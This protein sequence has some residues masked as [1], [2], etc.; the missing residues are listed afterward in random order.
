MYWI[1]SKDGDPLGFALYRRHYSAKK[2]PHPKIRQF[3]GPGETVVLMGFLCNAL[4]GWRKFIEDS[5]QKGVNCAVFRNETEH[6]SSDM[7]VEA[8]GFAWRRWP[9]ERLYTTIDTKEVRSSNPGCCFLKAGWRKCG[10]TKKRGLLIL[11]A[12][13]A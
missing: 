6:R 13:P 1:E 12:L 7:I 8:M 3:L 11:E 9:G 4:V 5:K 10:W 2:N